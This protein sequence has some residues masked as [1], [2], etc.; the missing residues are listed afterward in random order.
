MLP[1]SLPEP[2]THWRNWLDA[3]GVAFAVS[4]LVVLSGRPVS[5]L[6]ATT[7]RVGFLLALVFV[8]VGFGCLYR[9]QGE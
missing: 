4:I 2:F 7:V 8:F 1:K 9:R 6:G 5:G 3:G